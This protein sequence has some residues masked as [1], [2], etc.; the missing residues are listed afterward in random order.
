MDK[1]SE[2]KQILEEAEAVGQNAYEN[3]APKP[4]VVT[5]REDPFNDDSKVKQSWFVSEGVCGFAWLNIPGN[6]WFIRALKKAGFASANINNFDRK[7]VFKKDS[8]YKGYS[9]WIGGGQ[10]YE[11]KVAFANAFA[12]VLGSYN[13]VANVG[14]RLD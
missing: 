10:S 8:Y 12:D 14:S 5:E 13:I 2:A 4:M 9:Y 3:A 6:S 1:I 11:R 7:V